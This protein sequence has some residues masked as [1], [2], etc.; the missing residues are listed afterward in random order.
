MQRD[1][2]ADWDVI[3]THQ[4]YFGV[5]AN[6]RYLAH[7]I[8][9][10]AIEEFYNSGR[11]D[12]AHVEHVLSGLNGGRFRPNRALD[13][14]CG[15]GRLT[16][17]MA[18]RSKH[19]IGV[20]VADGMLR[21]ARDQAAARKCRNVEFTTTLPKEPVDWVNSLIVFQHIPPARGHALL[22]ELVDLL[23]PGGFFSV[24]LTFFRDHR[25][26]G[27]IDRDIAD[28][29]FDGTTVELLSTNT[30]PAGE[31]TMYDYDLNR[32]MRRLQAGLTPTHHGRS[33]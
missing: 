4:P 19:V 18:Q 10:D 8:T 1:T 28:Y 12:I 32:V 31:M 20:D 33:V 16:L 30:P 5:L 27:E 21:V 24:Q 7:N 11:K 2:D 15:V 25:H 26:T 9:P 17:A 29:R 13:F 22:A 6:E 14:G 3:A 23:A